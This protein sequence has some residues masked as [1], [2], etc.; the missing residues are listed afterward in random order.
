MWS[1]WSPLI[2]FLVA[3]RQP[4]D[5]RRTAVPRWYP[6]ELSTVA[7]RVLKHGICAALF[8]QTPNDTWNRDRCV[9]FCAH[10]CTSRLFIRR[11]RR[12]FCAEH[13][14]ALHFCDRT[15]GKQLQIP[16]PHI[17]PTNH[18]RSQLVVTASFIGM[19][20]ILFTG[21]LSILLLGNAANQC[22]PN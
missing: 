6:R 14:C 12:R 7:S 4:F 1:A 15:F 9:S 22:V 18:M 19:I 17:F 13:T 16:L 8:N 3:L 10:D 2:V 11:H 5:A 21:H 20:C